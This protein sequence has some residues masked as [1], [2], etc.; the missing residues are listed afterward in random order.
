MDSC[1]AHVNFS[2][3]HTTSENTEWNE[4]NR[5]KLIK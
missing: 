1:L 4:K 5:N 3:L 2:S